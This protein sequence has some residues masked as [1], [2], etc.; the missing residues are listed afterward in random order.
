MRPLYETSLNFLDSKQVCVLVGNELYFR[1][2]QY[3]EQNARALIATQKRESMQD[4][5]FRLIYEMLDT[6][7]DTVQKLPSVQKNSANANADHVILN[8]PVEFV[9]YIELLIGIINDRIIDKK[10]AIEQWQIMLICKAICTKRI[11][12]DSSKPQMSLFLQLQLIIL[13]GELGRKIQIEHLPPILNLITRYKLNLKESFLEQIN[14]YVAKQI[15]HGLNLDRNSIFRLIISLNS[16]PS[17]KITVHVISRLIEIY[18]QRL[19][20]EDLSVQRSEESRT[21]AELL[22]QK[23]DK[24]Q[25]VLPD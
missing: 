24:R 1:C 7:I 10:Q 21:R 25:R 11:F 17:E 5:D 9:N 19:S 16:Y 20:K 8:E 6:F 23:I 15:Q 12:L 3:G 4:A 18:L 22:L 13:Q 2:L 14:E